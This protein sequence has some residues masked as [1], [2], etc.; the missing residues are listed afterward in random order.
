MAAGANFFVLSG[1][2]LNELSGSRNAGI[3]IG[4]PRYPFHPRNEMSVSL[5]EGQRAPIRF[6]VER[7]CNEL[8]KYFKENYLKKFQELSLNKNFMKSVPHNPQ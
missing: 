2:E 6:L 5:Q 4:N 1:S 8:N 7:W 3:G